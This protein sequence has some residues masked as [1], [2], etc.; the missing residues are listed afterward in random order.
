MEQHDL[1]GEARGEMGIDNLEP[2][3][4]TKPYGALVT[5][6]ASPTAKSSLLGDDE[7]WVSRAALHPYPAKSSTL[8]SAETT[9]SGI[10]TCS[11]T[12]VAARIS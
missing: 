1:T 5:V 8:R 10:P 3:S 2:E 4:P 7:K 9:L 6:V 11:A 12:R